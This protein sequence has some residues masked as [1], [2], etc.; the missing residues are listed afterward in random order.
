[1]FNIFQFSWSTY[2]SKYASSESWLILISVHISSAIIITVDTIRANMYCF[3]LFYFYVSW[4]EL[5]PNERYTMTNEKTSSL[6]F[7]NI[8]LRKMQK[9]K[10][11]SN[12]I[13][14]NLINSIAITFKFLHFSQNY[15]DGRKRRCLL[16][17]LCYM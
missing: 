2:S 6:S 8:I 17:S 7:V 12:R 11:Y 14:L 4:N 3:M 15:I 16:I 10:S 9:F 5:K 1:L 13:N